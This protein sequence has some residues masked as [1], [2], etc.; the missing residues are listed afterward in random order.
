MAVQN[1]DET[2]EN[3]EFNFLFFESVLTSDN[4]DPNKNFLNDKLQLIDSPYYFSA[5]NFITISG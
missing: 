3:F 2:F 4:T 1:Q 5:E